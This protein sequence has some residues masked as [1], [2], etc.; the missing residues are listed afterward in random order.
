MTPE[1]DTKPAGG[2]VKPQQVG[3]KPQPDDSKT[4]VNKDAVPNFEKLSL[5][6]FGLPAQGAPGLTVEQLDAFVQR[7]EKVGTTI[8]LA[9]LASGARSAAVAPATYAKSAAQA[10]A[11]TFIELDKLIG[12]NK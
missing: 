8:A 6:E 3:V 10:A 9:I 1:K 5:G 7:L 2:A 12:E 4:T 11:E